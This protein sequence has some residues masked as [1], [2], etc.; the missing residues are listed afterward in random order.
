MTTTPKPP[1]P[2][3]VVATALALLLTLAGIGWSVLTATWQPFVLA[4]LVG[5]GLEVLA[6][7]VA[8][9]RGSRG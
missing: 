7:S 5:L 6:A 4:L 8:S 2:V 1:Q 3:M 9:L